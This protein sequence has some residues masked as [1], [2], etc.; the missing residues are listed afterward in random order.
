MIININNGSSLGARRVLTIPTPRIEASAPQ[1][2]SSPSVTVTISD[3]ARDLATAEP[4][5]FSA[6]VAAR[7]TNAFIHP[8]TDLRE[9]LKQYDFQNITPRQMR[10]LGNELFSRGEISEQANSS[11]GVALD[12][13]EPMP[14]DKPI[15]VISH[16]QKMNDM[17]EGLART[18]SA[19]FDYAIAHR[20]H[21]SQTFEDIRSF[22]ESDRK[23]VSTHQGV[24]V[25]DLE[26]ILRRDQREAALVLQAHPPKN[27]FG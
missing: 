12:L 17:V 13:N 4:N 21:L 2:F 11:F 6:E 26:E 7:G 8:D 16:F 10:H 3:A 1:I 14:L 15:D 23:E 20:K 9:L 19:N 24:T 22:V 18:D 5:P 25:K 27:I